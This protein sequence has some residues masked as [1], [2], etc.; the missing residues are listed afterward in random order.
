MINMY[1]PLMMWILKKVFPFGYNRCQYI[2]NIKI[3]T[4]DEIYCYAIT[5]NNTIET[6][7]SALVVIY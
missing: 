3:S 4:F 7:N 2:L 1:Q 5:N 6:K